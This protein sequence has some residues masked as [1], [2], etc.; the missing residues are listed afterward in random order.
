[1]KDFRAQERDMI[2]A[3]DIGTRS[4]VGVVGKP[5]GGR[6]KAMEIEM[7][8]H[9][10]R[11]MLDG[12]IDNIQQ[13]GALARTVTERLE[14]RLGV[15]LERVCVAA[16]GR[17]LRTQS[18][19]FALDLSDEK[20]I[21]AEMISR[22]EAGALSAAEDALQVE[23]EVRRQFFMVGY[24]VAQYRLDNYPLSSLLDHSGQKAEADVV[25]TFLPGEVV[26]SLYAAMRA[27]GLQVSSLT[28]EP[29]AAM[30]A[31]IP[32]ELRLLNLALVDIGAGTTD[33][34]VCRD[35]S[36]TGYTMAT[37]AGDEITEAIMRAY[38]VD[39]QTA[40]EMKRNLRPGEDAHY[41]DILGLENTATFEEIHTAIQ[42]PMGR[43]AEAIAAQVA[44][45]N[46]GA[47]SALFLAGGGS[48]LDGLREK[49]AASL[50]MDERRVAIAGSNYSKSAFADEIDLNNP[51]YATPLGIAVSAAL[52]LL[53]DSY[54][55][56]LNGETAKL[57]RSGVLTVRDIL[58]MNGYTYAD[59]LGRSGRN[60][61][62]TLNGRHMIL[63]GEPAVPAILRVNGEEAAITTV[64]HAGDS[65]RFQP[66]RSGADAAKTLGELLGKDFS[67]RVLLNNQEGDFKTPLRQGDVVLTLEGPGGMTP[68]PE[69]EEERVPAP[70]PAPA[71]APAP[72]PPPEPLPAPAETPAIETPAPKPLVRKRE[73]EI[74]LNGQ[75]M[76]LP[77]KE[78]GQPYYLMDLLE[79]SGVDFGQLEGP[80]HLLVNGVECGF[81]QAVKDRDTIIIR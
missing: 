73:V 18:G 38:L 5:S 1:M 70:S 33:I 7:A 64:V 65:I 2:F 15:R 12:Q 37:I 50:G 22:L 72:P 20:S 81:S 6:F 55:I 59:M 36:V 13:V 26:E 42:E 8:E 47:P 74:L 4:V 48:K 45:L 24:T 80:V 25:A 76:V 77:P 29:I 16:A 10:S 78:N 57:F 62:V 49:V 67:G 68:P 32:A 41:T 58:L 60:L 56:T 53:N 34:A 69:P 44:E 40:E 46:G 30:N 17:A 71:P 31:A 61:G 43:L 11:A 63:R 28:L 14:E 19:S 54:V 75:P 35:G 51:E 66:A 27:A 23:D 3:L 39:F 9:G 21:T 79:R 52:G